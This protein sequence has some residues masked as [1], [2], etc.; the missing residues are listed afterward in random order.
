M[1]SQAPHGSRNND[2]RR[3]CWHPIRVIQ[4]P[5][6]DNRQAAKHSTRTFPRS[7]VPVDPICGMEVEATA[8]TAE[9]DGQRFYFCCEHCR[10]KFLGQSQ[11]PHEPET[12][13]LKPPAAPQGKPR[14]A[15]Y[16]CPMCPG[17]ESEEPGSCPKCGMGLQP[18]AGDEPTGE[19]TYTCPMHPEVEQSE[20]GSCPRCGMDLQP[21]TPTAEQDDSELREMTRRFWVA[22]ALSL[23]VMLLA[24]GPMLGLRLG[25]TLA[26]YSPWIQFALATPVV[27]WGAG[28]FFQRG[29]RSLLTGQF[30]MFTL[31]SMGV[32]VAYGYSVAAVLFPGA[33]PESFR[34]KGE[35]AL[36]F[37]AAAMITTLVLL[38]QVLELRGRQRTGS[39][40]REL[41][42]L[43]PPTARRVRDEAAGEG[44]EQTVALEQ[45][46]PGDQLRV[47]PGERIPVDGKV[48]EGSGTVD[49]SMLTGEPTPLE[50]ATGDEVVGGTI[51]QAGSFVMQAQRV[52]EE[53]MLGQIIDM[54]A[55]AQRSRAPIQRVADVVAGY[56]VPAVI[57][58]A[59]VSFVA[60]SIFGPE[61]R[62]AHALLSAVAVLIVACPCALGLA[63][64]MSI[65]VGM[66]RGA[67]EG[68]LIKDAEVLER[69]ERVDTVVVDKTGTLTAG[70]PSVVE[71]AAAD[72]FTQEELIRAAA[73]AE[74]NSEHPLA[75]AV[76]N[77]ATD[78]GV[79]LPQAADF[80]SLTGSGVKCRVEAT[81]VLVGDTE[82]LASHDVE[83]DKRFFDTADQ[84][85]AS[86][87]TVIFVAV[88]GRAAGILALAD[89]IKPSTP[90]A[91]DKLHKLGLHVIMLTGDHRSTAEAVARELGIDEVEAEV[92]PQ[93]KGDAVGKLRESGRVVAMAGDGINDAPALAAADVGIAMGTGTDVA[94]QSAGVT[95]T[96]GDL[97]GIVKALLLSRRV[98]RNIRQNLFFAFIYN[99]LGVPVAAGLLYP[100]FGIRLSPMLAAAAMSMSSVSVIANSLRLRKISL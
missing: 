96:S 70:Q 51:N 11:G 37:E 91:I 2:L 36:Y 26:A 4:Q 31:I 61:P 45:V 87:K 22:L 89:T 23:P 44:G 81:A 72:G 66:G 40:L 86:G 42:S 24:M 92:R 43:K 8:L 38:G 85:R 52:G 82:L 55:Q 21:Q 47:R 19:V 27:L 68:V 93:D 35:V 90:A 94:M 25:D 16:Y 32:A 13:E 39:A 95:L 5:T 58:V 64:P 60:W 63:T 56:F 99:S 3:F 77:K 83:I 10:S 76:V 97:R 59:M 20:P 98:M 57:G 34:H 48:L 12:V 46:R 88:D 71:I 75:R 54:V 73:A 67:S 9:R 53:T 7:I 15:R 28:P 100:V 18:T 41:L 17:V 1:R 69:M 78:D 6:R 80:E 14:S 62:L 50:K 79:K 30:N 29:G 84:W 65:T 33:F 49:E 74:Q